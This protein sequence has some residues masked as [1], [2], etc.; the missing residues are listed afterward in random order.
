MK[1]RPS[2]QVA[3]DS[4]IG[5][6]CGFSTV[7]AAGDRASHRGDKIVVHLF[8]LVSRPCCELVACLR[9]GIS[10]KF[11]PA[12]ARSGHGSG[13]RQC[14]RSGIGGASLI[15]YATSVI[16]AIGSLRGPRRCL[17]A[18]PIDLP[19]ITVTPGGTP[20]RRRSFPPPSASAAIAN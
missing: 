7:A 2:S 12:M 18:S 1:L 19:P 16:R 20:P 5:R 4:K 9:L 3:T 6:A 17:M 14:K 11:S 10:K 15:Q 8:E 13:L